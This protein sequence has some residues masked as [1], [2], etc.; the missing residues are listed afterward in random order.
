VLDALSEKHVIIVGDNPTPR[1]NVPRTLALNGHFEPIHP[2]TS[3]GLF[4]IIYGYPNVKLIELS[5]ALCSE[6]ACPPEQGLRALYS[7]ENHIS[8]YTANTI[9]TAFLKDRLSG[10]MPATSPATR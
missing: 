1:F 2:S 7:N 8:A 5:D 6:G 10:I 9:V 3:A 4:H